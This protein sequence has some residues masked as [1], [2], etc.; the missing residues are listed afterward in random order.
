[1]H[2]CAE[3][4]LPIVGDLRLACIEYPMF[5]VWS[6]SGLNFL[7]SVICCISKR[8]VIELV[9]LVNILFQSTT[10]FEQDS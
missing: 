1:M 8:L 9:K 2:A 10:V 3:A 7:L 6:Y 4:G 5:Q